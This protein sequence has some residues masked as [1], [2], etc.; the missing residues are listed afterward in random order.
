[1]NK[2]KEYAGLLNEAAPKN[3]FLA[4]ITED[5]KD[6]LVKAGGKETPTISGILAYPPPGEYGGVG[7]VGDTGSDY[8]QF[9]RAVSQAAN[10]PSPS[11]PSGNDNNYQDKIQRISTGVEPGYRPQDAQPYGLSKE[12][13]YRQGKITKDQYESTDVAIDRSIQESPSWFDGIKNYIESG[14]M[15]G[16]AINLT[17]EVLSKLGEYSS[18][19]QKKAMTMSLNSRVKSKMKDLDLNNPNSMN[20]PEIADLHKDLAGIEAG[21]FT[22]TDFTEKYGSGDLGGEGEGGDRELMNTFVPYAAHA[23]GGTTPQSS[24][25][26]EYFANLGNT[27]LGISNDFMTKYN[28]A[29]TNMASILDMTP[30]TQQYGY[31]NTFASTYPRA[32]N[33]G[34]VFYQYLNEQGLI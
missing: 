15:I 11:A 2:L 19:L 10:N 32:M 1:M 22:Q 13:A 20:N 9:D 14:G 5:E 4:Y 17:G 12:E 26:N 29:K 24:M 33:S 7:Y 25:V 31:G 30:N 21:T 27:N 18:E 8:G 3:H 23:V 16:M 34:N 28:T 6:M